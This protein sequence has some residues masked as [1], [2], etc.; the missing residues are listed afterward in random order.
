[1]VSQVVS[2]PATRDEWINFLT[3]TTQKNDPMILSQASRS[4]SADAPEQ[5]LQMISR[6]A[7]LLRVATAA[8]SRLLKESDIS[9]DDLKFWWSALGEERGLWEKTKEPGNLT[10]LW[11]DAETAVKGISEW[12][13]NTGTGD[14]TFAKWREDRA[15]DIS[16]LGGCERIAL[17]GLGL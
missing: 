17:W 1:M 4:D 7:L 8:S 6:A 10:D 13:A 9:S 15:Y 11:A 5:H 2:D 12:S 3:R 14:K 16:V